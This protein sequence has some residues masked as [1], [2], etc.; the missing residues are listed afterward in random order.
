[1]DPVGFEANVILMQYQILVGCGYSASSTV[2][3]VETMD[4]Y[5]SSLVELSIEL[6]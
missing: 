1:M 4:R 2:S 6:H 5:G 3:E